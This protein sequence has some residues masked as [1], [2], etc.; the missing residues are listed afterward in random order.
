MRP[1]HRRAAVT[2]FARFR[3]AANTRTANELAR[4]GHDVARE[5]LEH[6]RA[7]QRE[8]LRPR[9]TAE[10]VKQKDDS[11]YTLQREGQAVRVEI[12]LLLKNRGNSTATK[13]GFDS[14]SVLVDG[15][16]PDTEMQ[17][18]F[19]PSID[20]APGEAIKCRHQ[21][22]FHSGVPDVF[23]EG[24][25]RCFQFGRVLVY[26]GDSGDERYRTCFS[27]E[28]RPEGSRV[29]EQRYESAAP[30]AAPIQT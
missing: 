4:K 17:L 21:F 19:G 23:E 12:T 16:T 7:A 3:E 28:I 30:S 15:A 5:A 2:K 8:A 13:V 26:R 25:R 6:S 22:G 1:P 9:I 10:V 14:G 18:D 20:L 24:I 29:L 27:I 11:L